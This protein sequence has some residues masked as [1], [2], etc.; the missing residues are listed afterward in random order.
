MKVE[1]LHQSRDILEL[2]LII[3][4][5]LQINY[6]QLKNLTGNLMINWKWAE[7]IEHK[8]KPQNYLKHH[9]ITDSAIK[10]K[11]ISRNP[12]QLIVCG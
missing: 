4:M 7:G 9:L 10:Q 1:L 5:I 6:N 8:Q 3:F 2:I 12:K 11:T